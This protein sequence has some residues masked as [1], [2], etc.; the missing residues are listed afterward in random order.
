MPQTLLNYASHP[1]PSIRPLALALAML[2]ASQ[3][4]AQGL[5]EVV[6]TAQKREQSL[7]EAPIAISAFDQGE[8]QQRGIRTLVDLGSI[9]PNVKVAPLPTNTAKATVAIRGSVTINPASYWEPTVGIYRDGASVA[10]CSG[11]VGRLAEV[12]R[13]EVLRGTQGTLFGRI[14]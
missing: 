6:V 11:H 2:A 9:A 7:Q 13:I 4:Q 14:T 3:V 5:E 8:L 1:P 10:K 12:D